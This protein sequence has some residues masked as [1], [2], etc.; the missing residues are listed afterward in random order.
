[1][2]MLDLRMLLRIF[3]WKIFK[4]MITTIV[5]Q[6]KLLLW[7]LSRLQFNFLKWKTTHTYDINSQMAML[8]LV[9]L[10]I[11]NKA[12]HMRIA[13]KMCLSFFHLVF[14]QVGSF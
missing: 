6:H 10:Q 11:Y 1:M 14:K 2:I 13:S 12:T 4:A 7:G 3:C 8:L 5:Q 9:L